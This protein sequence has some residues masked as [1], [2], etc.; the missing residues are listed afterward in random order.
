MAYFLG[1]RTVVLASVIGSL[2][3]LA[4]VAILIW[5]GAG[6]WRN[7]T[8]LSPTARSIGPLLF[9]LAFHFSFS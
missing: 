8:R 2:F 3:A 1:L 7:R 5:H 4:A 9:F 6:L